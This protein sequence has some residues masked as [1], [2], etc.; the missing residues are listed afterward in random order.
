ME[1]LERFFVK[2]KG[3]SMPCGKRT[4]ALFSRAIKAGLLERRTCAFFGD[5][6]ASVELVFTSEARKKILKSLARKHGLD[7]DDV[8]LLVRT[9]NLEIRKCRK[10]AQNSHVTDGAIQSTLF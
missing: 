8:E 7:V 4:S 5:R 9:G 2:E 10:A 1:E 6:K 3:L